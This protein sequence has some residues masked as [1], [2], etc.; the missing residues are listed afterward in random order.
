LNRFCGSDVAQSQSQKKGKTRNLKEG[1]ITVLLQEKCRFAQWGVA[2]AVITATGSSASCKLQQ[3][4]Q[5]HFRFD[6]LLPFLCDWRAT[7]SAM[8]LHLCNVV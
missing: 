5:Q 4:E 1:F 7:G 2:A 6:L 8:H 3:R